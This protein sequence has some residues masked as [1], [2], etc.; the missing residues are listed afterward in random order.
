MF[1]SQDTLIRL[2]T[3]LNLL[4][5]IA[6]LGVNYLGTTGFFNGKG[7]AEVSKKYQTLITP[8]GF[9]FSIWGVIY[10][11]LLGT[12]V[13][14]FLQ[15]KDPAVG[16]LIQVISGLFIVSSLFNMGWI[17]AFSYEK[18]GL[19]TILIFGML[20]S[21]M[22]II[23]EIYI[24][25]GDFPYTLAAIAFTLY[26]SWVFIA[27]ILN[28]SLY[29]V[30]KNWKA[31]GISHSV[32]T[33]IILFIAILFVLFY[34]SIYRNAIFP[35]A[36]AWAFFGIYSSYT[37]G[38]INPPMASKIKLVLIFGIII[39]ITLTGYTFVGNDYS[40]FPITK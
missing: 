25:R 22:L 18:L 11:L 32:W 33:I 21:L 13:F 3:I 10:M 28:V 7:Q 19:S 17:V 16:M 20:L 29:L 31:F 5:F 23:K 9:A 24:G 26:A 34:V 37:N 1:E 40:I 38:I 8:N 15:R 6:T 4:V 35:L 30:Q 27:T 39:F 2:L 14:F 12:L 36:L